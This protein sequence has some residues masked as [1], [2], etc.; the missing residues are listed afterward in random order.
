MNQ[1]VYEW[2]KD[3]DEGYPPEVKSIK[4][5]LS[6]VNSNFVAGVILDV[7]TYLCFGTYK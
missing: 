7:V 4:C 5:A 1:A 6:G 3:D 2:L